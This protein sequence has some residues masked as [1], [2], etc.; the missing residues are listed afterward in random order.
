MYELDVMSSEELSDFDLELGL[1]QLEALEAPGFW[2]GYKEGL[3]VFVPLGVL[4]VA[5]MTT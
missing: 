2:S 3:I 1:Q 4:F 5:A